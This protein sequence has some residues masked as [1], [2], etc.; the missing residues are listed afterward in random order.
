MSINQGKESAVVIDRI[1]S[2]RAKIGDTMSITNVA[3]I[4]H[5]Q[6]WLALTR[7]QIP[8][9]FVSFSKGG[10]YSLVEDPFNGE[11]GRL[12]MRFRVTCRK[13]ADESDEIGDDG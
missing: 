6:L 5:V 12:L 13:T 1:N 8:F 10:D 7:L 4:A 2:Y 11:N 9:N 3:N